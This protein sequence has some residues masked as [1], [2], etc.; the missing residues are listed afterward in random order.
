VI[1]NVQTPNLRNLNKNILSKHFSIRT[2]IFPSGQ[3]S[4]ESVHHHQHD[5][6]STGK[7]LPV[8]KGQSGFQSKYHHFTRFVSYFQAYGMSAWPLGLI[9]GHRSA[10]S[11]MVEVTDTRTRNKGRLQALRDKVKDKH[12]IQP[13]LSTSD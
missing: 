11:E 13:H 10:K 12:G 2:L 6:F 5:I 9:L 3:S 8:T 7:K 4:S 1:S